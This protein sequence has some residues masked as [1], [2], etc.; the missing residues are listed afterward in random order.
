MKE[1]KAI[2][3]F[4][5]ELEL[6]LLREGIRIEYLEDA[7]VLDE[8]V[9][10]EA[11][12]ENQRRRWLSAQFVYFRRFAWDGLI[13]FLARFNIDFFDKVYQM[14]LP[15]RILLLGLLTMVTITLGVLSLI[16]YIWVWETFV[17]S[18]MNWLAIWS[19]T[20]FA[21]LFSIPGKLYNVHTL[22]AVMSLPRGF[23]LMFRSLFKLRNANKTFIHTEHGISPKDTK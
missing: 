7:V 11:V 1:I 5:K 8:K 21:L 9:Q 3:G 12:F 2:G 17:F 13:Q 16:D 4:D 20:A 10:K 15:P 22:L 6:T 14:I 23:W 19:F 18:F